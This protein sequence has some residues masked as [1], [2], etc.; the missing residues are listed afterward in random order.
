MLE[1]VGHRVGRLRHVGVPE[2]GERAGGCVLD[3][4]HRRLEHHRE[5][6]LGA[7][8]EAVETT[9]ALGQQVLEGVA[10]HLAAEAPE[11]GADRAEVLVDQG[12]Q[13]LDSARPATGDFAWWSS[14]VE[15]TVPSARSTVSASTLS[16]VRP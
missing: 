14:G 13:G 1:Q 16:T 10:R 4:A 9:P 6:A 5:G 15:T 7:D 8:Q 2:D 12:V 3:Q 11:L